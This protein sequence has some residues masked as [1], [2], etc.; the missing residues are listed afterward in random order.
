MLYFVIV[1][2]ILYFCFI[3]HLATISI[4]TVRLHLFSTKH[5]PNNV[6]FDLIHIDMQTLSFLSHAT[7][8]KTYI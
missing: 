8:R 6:S 4:F 5:E 7:V 3:I 2:Y 1:I